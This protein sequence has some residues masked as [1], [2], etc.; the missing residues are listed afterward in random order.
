MSL[1]Q[2]LAKKTV[3]VQALCEQ[4]HHQ[5]N[6]LTIVLTGYLDFAMKGYM[7]QRIDALKFSQT[8]EKHGLQGNANNFWN[9]ISR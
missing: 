2:I 9:D 8:G 6:T 3:F 7:G 1:T 5:F 4:Q